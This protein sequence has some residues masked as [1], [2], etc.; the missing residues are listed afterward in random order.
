[1]SRVKYLNFLQAPSQANILKDMI[2][3]E[4]RA[5]DLSQGRG[6][7]P[8]ALFL[9]TG[10][11]LQARPR[12]LQRRSPTGQANKAEGEDIEQS[13]LV[14]DLKK[15]HEQQQQICPQVIPYIIST[16]QKSA[17]DEKLFL[18]SDFTSDDRRKLGLETLGAEELK[19]QEGEANDA[20][21][22]LREHIRHSQ[23]LRHHKN[24]R[25]NAVHGQDKNTRAVHKIQDVQT[26]IQDYVKKYQ[27]ARLAMISLG[28]NTRDSRYP[29]LKDEDLYTKSVNEPHNLGDGSKLEGWIWRKGHHGNM[30]EVEEAEYTL[31]SAKVQWHRARADIERW[32]EEVEILAQEFRRAIQGFQKM[33]GVWNALARDHPNEPGTKV[34]AFKTADMYEKMSREAAE[35]FHSTGGTWPAPGVSLSQHVRSERPDRTIDWNAGLAG[36]N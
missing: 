34:Y 36:K 22:S 9:H 31:D 24:S 2:A 19:L 30:S 10:L 23:A 18:P 6:T 15:W 8:I 5:D 26:K 32:Q 27:Q 3:A 14:A 33:Q 28:L 1:M 29:E 17:Q 7:T 12:A 35:K 16:P 20:L 25:G 11:K 4:H 13:R 21:R